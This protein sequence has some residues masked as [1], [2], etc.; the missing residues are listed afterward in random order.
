MQL[1]CCYQ[2]DSYSGRITVAQA[3][4]GSDFISCKADLTTGHDFLGSSPPLSGLP[5]LPAHRHQC[6]S[7]VRRS[8]PHPR[9][10]IRAAHVVHGADPDDL[11][12]ASVSAEP[13]GLA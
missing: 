2:F 6:L 4:L 13:G 5:G 1:Q 12:G 3:V 9:A 7:A 10:W 8:L 11:R